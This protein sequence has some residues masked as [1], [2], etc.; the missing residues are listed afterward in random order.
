MN[1]NNCGFVKKNTPREGAAEGIVSSGCAVFIDPAGITLKFISAS[2]GKL[3]FQQAAVVFLLFDSAIP[4][5]VQTPQ[6]TRSIFLSTEGSKNFRF[7]CKNDYRVI[8]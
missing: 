5:Y 1:Y 8:I 4:S 6:K 3:F 2:N 7:F